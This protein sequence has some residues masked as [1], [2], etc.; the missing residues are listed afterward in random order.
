MICLIIIIVIAIVTI[1]VLKI[2]GKTPQVSIDQ[3]KWSLYYYLI[4]F[5][6]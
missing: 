2:I 6:N 1:I 5:Y 3:L 4:I